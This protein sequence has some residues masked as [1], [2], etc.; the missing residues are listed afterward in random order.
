MV[1]VKTKRCQFEGC[2]A[3]ASYG[4]SGFQATACAQHRTVGMRRNPRRRCDHCRQLATHGASLHPTCCEEHAPPEFRNL[5]LRRCEGCN[6]PEILDATDH[7]ALCN[8]E[9]VK[10]YRQGCLLK[11]RQVKSMLD[12]NGLVYTLYDRMVEGGQ[13]GGRERP[14]FLFEATERYGYLVILEVDEQQHKRGNYCE[15]GECVR[16]RNLAEMLTMPTI[17]V[18]YNP[19]AYRVTVGAPLNTTRRLD[20]LRRFLNH[21]L[22]HR[23]K[24]LEEFKVEGEFGVIQLFYDHY[25]EGQPHVVTWPS[26]GHFV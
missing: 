26:N 22:L 19:D 10:R 15:S 8:P 2:T 12:A 18:R 7:C 4:L 23:D 1:D 16:M 11:Q 13:C 3:R 14:D 6:L 17:F 5:V 21:H 20:I 25:Q 24:D 9:A